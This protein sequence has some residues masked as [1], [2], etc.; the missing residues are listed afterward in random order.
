MNVLKSSIAEIGKGFHK[1]AEAQHQLLILP[2][3]LLM[4]AE[5]LHFYKTATARNFLKSAKP[6][7][8]TV[9]N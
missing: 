6:L 3:F 4:R 8:S 7:T 9:K 5:L 2:D 1:L